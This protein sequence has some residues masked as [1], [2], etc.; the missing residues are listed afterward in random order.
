M[1]RIVCNAT[2][3]LPFLKLPEPAAISITEFARTAE[4]WFMSAYQS[5]CPLPYWSRTFGTVSLLVL[6]N[7][8]VYVCSINWFIT[9]EM[10][11]R[12]RPTARNSQDRPYS[13]LETRIRLSSILDSFRADWH[14][15][16]DIAASAN[17][18][19][20][21]PADERLAICFVVFIRDPD[22]S[23]PLSL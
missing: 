16:A 11:T 15:L 23:S 3:V 13:G 21:T 8:S 1:V 20:E 2:A 5:D 4:H 6:V 17:Q 12:W 9:D 18:G 10:A 22:H 7:M 19:W 14:T